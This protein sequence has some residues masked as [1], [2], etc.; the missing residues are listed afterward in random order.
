MSKRS[1]RLQFSEEEQQNPQLKK[2]VRKAK[3]ASDKLDKA[4]AKIPKNKISHNEKKPPPKLVHDAPLNLLSTQIQRETQFHSEIQE[5]DDNSAVEAVNSGVSTAETLH[6]VSQHRKLQPYRAAHNAEIQADKAN[7]N[8]LQKE[9]R[10]SAPN[11]SAYS[12]WQQRKAIRQEYAAAKYAAAKRTSENT[13]RASE[14]AS[15][16]VSKASSKAKHGAEFVQKNWKVLLIVLALAA[17][18][19]IV[20]SIISSCTMMFQGIFGSISAT[21][22]PSEPEDMIDV[23]SAYKEMESELQYKLDNYESLSGYDEYHITGTV[24]GHDPYVLASI[25]SAIYGEYTLSDVQA[26]LDIIFNLQYQLTENI[27]TETRYQ[28]ETRTGYRQVYDP[29][30]GETYL[31]PYTYTI[32]EPYDYTICTVALTCTPM[33]DLADVLLNDEQK[34]LYEVYLETKGNYPDLFS[35]EPMMASL[36]YSNNLY[37]S[38]A[39]TEIGTFAQIKAEAERFLGYPY[40]WGGSSPETSFDCSGFVSWVY[41]HSGWNI[42]RCTAQGL[43]NLCTPISVEEIQPGDFVFFKGTYATYGISHVGIYAGNDEMLHAG[44]PISYADL[45]QPYWQQHLYAYGR[46]P[47]Q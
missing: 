35:E 43:Y 46:L 40:V 23:E 29:D 33:E 8:A 6:H 21:T 7:L 20:M 26:M 10:Q 25:L 22:Y 28:T 13:A 44:N 12:R 45:N 11:A 34:K 18:L 27:V 9:V 2:A 38:D 41:N 15:K 5:S 36:S 3:K 17:L 37:F 31:V 47:E 24:L 42:G 32:E 4:E 30:T 1:P 16:A 19:M 39:P 14:I